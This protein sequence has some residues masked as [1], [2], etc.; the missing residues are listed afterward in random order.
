MD[1][2]LFPQIYVKLKLNENYYLFVE[3]VA[4]KIDNKTYAV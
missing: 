1:L 2:Q 4:R 3:N